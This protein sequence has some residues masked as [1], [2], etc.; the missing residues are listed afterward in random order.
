[1]LW[2]PA[3]QRH[4]REG[5]GRYP[6]HPLKGNNDLF[7][8]YPSGYKN[9]SI[10]SRPGTR[11]NKGINLSAQRAW[12]RPIITNI[13]FTR[14]TTRRPRSPRG[15]GWFQRKNRINPVCC[16]V[17]GAYHQTGVC[18]LPMC[19]LRLSCDNLAANFVAFGEQAKGLLDGGVDLLLPETITIT[20]NVRAAL[21]CSSDYLKKPANGFR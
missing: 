5:S 14:S 12:R 19:A 16:R 7:K 13:S 6:P 17:D 3:I 18:N 4:L 9:G 2:A 20:L 8:H 10:N 11:Y 15:G 21:F 1:M